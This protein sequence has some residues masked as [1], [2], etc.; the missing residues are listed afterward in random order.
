M[1]WRMADPSLTLYCLQYA[2]SSAKC[3]WRALR[4]SSPLTADADHFKLDCKQYES[5]YHMRIQAMK[6]HSPEWRM[7][8]LKEARQLGNVATACKKFGMDRTTFYKLRKRCDPLPEGEWLAAL[9]DHDRT[10]KTHPQQTPDSERRVIMNLA[11]THPAWGCN[12]I[13]EELETKRIFRSHNTVQTILNKETLERDWT[14]GQLSIGLT[15][16]IHGSRSSSSRG[17]IRAIE[18][19]QSGKTHLERC[20]LLRRSKLESSKGWARSSFS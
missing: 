7:M 14:G 6:K 17:S 8:V 16:S 18:I 5:R 19:G 3:S 11:L 13:E 2:I 10:W 12:R 20:Y 4:C 15:S 1:P 9:R